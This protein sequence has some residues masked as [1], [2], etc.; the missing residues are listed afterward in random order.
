M[1][2]GEV[3][4]VADC[5]GGEGERYYAG[6]EGRHGGVYNVSTRGNAGNF[7]L[8]PLTFI[9][10]LSGLHR[11]YSSCTNANIEISICERIVT[12]GSLAGR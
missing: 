7:Q 3:G 9:P 2:V 8:P 1:L 5:E 4:A 10:I 6:V 11:L 12:L